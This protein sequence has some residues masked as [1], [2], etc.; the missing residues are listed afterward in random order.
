MPSGLKI[1]NNYQT[2]HHHYRGQIDHTIWHLLT[3]KT[4]PEPVEPHHKFLGGSEALIGPPLPHLL[5]K[6]V[7][8]IEHLLHGRQNQHVCTTNRKKKKTNMVN[9]SSLNIIYIKSCVLKAN[10][11][12]RIVNFE[13]K[14]KNTSNHIETVFRQTT[15]QNHICPNHMTHTCKSLCNQLTTG[16]WNV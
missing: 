13:E 16:L 4:P 10:N 1:Q 5:S 8:A 15:K 3:H 12:V 11:K 9:Q 14:F 6:K 7:P 2:H